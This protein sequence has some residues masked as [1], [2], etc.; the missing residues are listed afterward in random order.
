MLWSTLE[1]QAI[2]KVTVASRRYRLGFPM[3][4]TII[5]GAVAQRGIKTYK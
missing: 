3:E 1:E 4:L 2:R 5:A